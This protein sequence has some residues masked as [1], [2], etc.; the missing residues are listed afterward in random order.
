MRE[1]DQNVP[2][3]DPNSGNAAITPP[4]GDQAG[5]NTAM[6]ACRQLMPNGGQP[7][8]PDPQDLEGLRQYAACM[9]EHGVETTDPDPNTGNSQFGGRFANMSRSQIVN[10]PT[11]K[12]AD[13]ACKDKL[14]SAGPQKDNK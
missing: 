11:Y 5:W 3:P 10:D 6:G 2:D 8:A 7:E 12:A 4:A 1:H 13:V 14:P 9:R